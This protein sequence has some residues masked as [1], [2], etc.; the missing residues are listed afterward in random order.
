MLKPK[1]LKKGDLV[2]IAAP[3]GPFDRAIFMQAV[4]KLQGLGFKVTFRNDI[5]A[6]DRYFAGSDTR[7]A[8]EL[9]RFFADPKVRAVFFAR[10]GYG[11]QRILHLLDLEA[12]RSDPKVVLGY[13]DITALHSFLNRHGIGGTFYGVNIARH[14]KQA[15][16]STVELLVRA[17]TDNKPLGQL[18]S[19]GAKTLKSGIAE[20]PLAGGC[21]SLIAGGI[22]TNFDLPTEDCILFLEDV[23]E[24]VYKYD[25]MLNHLK[26]AGKLRGVRA[27]VF[28]TMTLPKGE[29]KAWLKKMIEDVLGDFPGPIVTDFPTG[30]LPFNKLFVTLPLGVKAILTAGK[31]VSLEMTESALL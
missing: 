16:K 2:A 29:N 17:V 31:K 11:T 18:T 14:F 20:G 4:K 3:A 28:G 25:R 24:P 10:G 15:A 21:L 8:D 22:G 6:R 30:H 26:L 19:R 5:F 13:S 27:I 1:A 12:I 9:F 7:R 23:L